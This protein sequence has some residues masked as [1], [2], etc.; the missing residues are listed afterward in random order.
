M[1]GNHHTVRNQRY[2]TEKE[3]FLD[4]GLMKCKKKNGHR[5]QV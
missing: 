1:P 3:Y 4:S 5:E 2:T